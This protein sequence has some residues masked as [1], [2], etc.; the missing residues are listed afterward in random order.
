MNSTYTCCICKDDFS[1]F[2]N[3]P[4]PLK[5]RGRCCDKC[6]IEKVLTL[7]IYL[8]V[9]SKSSGGYSTIH[10][11]KAKKAILQGDLNW[12][13]VVNIGEIFNINKSL[14]DN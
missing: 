14:R 9:L 11:E 13:D 7:R 6:N 2:G 10:L 5:K 1:G 4:Q 8:H 12:K 3:N